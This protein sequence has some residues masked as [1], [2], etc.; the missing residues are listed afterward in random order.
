M[1]YSW[2]DVILTSLFVGLNKIFFLV[3]D[4]PIL[5]ELQPFKMQFLEQREHP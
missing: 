2:S 4:T 5:S 1:S 3:K